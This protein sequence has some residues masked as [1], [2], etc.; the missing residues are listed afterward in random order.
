MKLKTFYIVLITF[1]TLSLSQKSLAQ[2]DPNGIDPPPDPVD[3]PVDGGLSILLAAGIAYGAKK[4]YDNRKKRNE[5]E[6]Y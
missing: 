2:N 6:G 4:G 3:T 5:I 1:I